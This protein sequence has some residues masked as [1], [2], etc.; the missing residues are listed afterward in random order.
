[1]SRRSSAQGSAIALCLAALACTPAPAAEPAS[2]LFRE[3]IAGCDNLGSCVAQS[4]P[5]EGASFAGMLRLERKAGAAAEPSLSLILRADTLREAPPVA[6]SIDSQ[7]FP[8]SGQTPAAT[9]VDLETARVTFSAE[10][11]LTLIEAARKATAVQATMAKIRYDAS[12]SGAVAALL[13][14]DEQQGRLGTADALIRKGA[15][16]ATQA[17][18]AKPLPVVTTMPT[19]GL[20]ALT[21][22][23]VK[24]MT[25]ALRAR[26]A[27]TDPDCEDT[28]SLREMD[29]AVALSRSENLVMLSCFGGAYNYATGFWIMPGAD[30]GKARKL[31][32]QR[33]GKPTGNRLINAEYS[34]ET[35]KLEFNEK[36]RGPGDCGSLGVYAWTGKDFVLTGYEDMPTCRGLLPGDDWLVL[37]RSE[38]RV[39]K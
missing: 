9:I 34:P 37:W 21:P 39:G 31:A 27:K 2:K 7:P 20:P 16:P 8:A 38:V 18:Q 22:A 4:M 24:A 25:T 23:R 12:L 36:G 19:A 26:V 15:N 13:W 1:M 5:A 17:P 3:W 33:P 32:F 28:E 10:Q 14:I 29:R 35:G 6:I 11:T 30:A